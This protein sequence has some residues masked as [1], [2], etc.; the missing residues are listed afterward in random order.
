MI[1]PVA[2]VE[3]CFSLFAVLDNAH[4]EGAVRKWLAEVALSMPD[5]L[6]VAD[7][8]EAATADGIAFST[9]EQSYAAD[10]TQVTWRPGRPGSEGAT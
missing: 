10:V 6:G 4:D 3:L 1:G 7:Q 2:A 9:V 8:L 5:D